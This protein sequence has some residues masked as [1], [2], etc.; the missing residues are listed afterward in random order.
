MGEGVII[1]PGYDPTGES[2]GRG[3]D[4]KSW[5]DLN[6]ESDG[7]GSDHNRNATGLLRK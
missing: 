4:H 1:S 2:D 5:Y 6:G 3:S 7:R